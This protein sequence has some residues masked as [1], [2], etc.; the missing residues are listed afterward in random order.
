MNQPIRRV[1]IALSLVCLGLV[2]AGLNVLE[3]VEDAVADG[4]AVPVALG[5]VGLGFFLAVASFAAAYWVL[6]DL[7]DSAVPQTTKWFAGAAS[8]VGVGAGLVV[9]SQVTQSELR[10]GLLFLDVL[11]IGALDGI[12]ISRTSRLQ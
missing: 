12:A 2:V 4:E 6:V 3:L 7:P 1:G 9:L 5:E 11:A 8:V 10:P